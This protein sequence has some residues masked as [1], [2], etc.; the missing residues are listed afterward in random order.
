MLLITPLAYAGT[1]GHYY[2]GILGMRDIILPPKGF[3]ALYYDPIYYSNTFRNSH[4]HDL[5]NFSA[6][7][8]ETKNINVYGQNIPMRLSFGLTADIDVKMMFTTQ[9]LLLVWAPGWKFFGADYGMIVAPSTGYVDINAK[10]KVH[11]AGTV[12]IANFSGTVTKDATIKLQSDDYGFGDLFVQ[13]LMLDWRGKRYDIGLYYGFFAPTGTYSES[14]LANVGMGFWT[15]QF[16]TFAAYY[17]D[18]NRKTALIV[19]STYDLNSKKY[20]QDLTPG[21]SLTLEYA[22]SH[23][24]NPRIEIGPCGYDQW[25]VSSD[26][27]TAAKNKN[28]FYQIHGIGG[29][30]TGWVIKEKFNIT[31]KCI[32]EYYGVD[33]FRGVLGTVN[34]TWVF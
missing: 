28:V 32:A 2:P 25:Q 31:T 34:L 15:Q 12:S 11:A 14:R 24:L 18:K 26:T 29:Q 10:V 22:L 19:T 20:A 3:Y 8:S 4:G 33:R 7:G 9:Q 13:P 27:G 1:L 23:Y 16:Q 30:L 17:F 21:Q 6:S 5:G